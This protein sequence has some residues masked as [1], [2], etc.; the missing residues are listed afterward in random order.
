LVNGFKNAGR[1]EVKFDASNLASG[2]YVYRLSA[3][4]FNASKKLMLLK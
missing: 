1:Y 4:D 2:V 3:G